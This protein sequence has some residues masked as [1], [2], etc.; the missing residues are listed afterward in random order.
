MEV[1]RLVDRDVVAEVV[2]EGET[3]EVVKLGLRGFAL[4]GD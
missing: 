2:R 4:I 1:C 3:E